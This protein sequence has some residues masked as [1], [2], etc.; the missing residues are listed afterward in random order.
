MI[1]LLIGIVL[2]PIV[3]IVFFR[4]I[5]T[6]RE[7]LAYS[8]NL[9][10]ET[11]TTPP[12]TIIK[13]VFGADAFTEDNTGSWTEQD[14]DGPVEMIFSFQDKNDPAL[15]V[16]EDTPG[17]AEVLVNPVKPGYSGKMSNLYYGQ[18]LAHH[19]FIVMSDSDT[20]ADTNTLARMVALHEQGA[21][22]ITNLTRY[23][24]AD[25]LWG[26]IYAAFWNFE[27]IG[28][29]APSIRKHG[30]GAIGNTI[31]MTQ[32]TLQKLGGLKVFRDYVAED[33]AMG[34]KAEELGIRVDL[35]PIIDSPVG[36]M[37]LRS[38]LNK[39]S[40]AALFGITMKAGNESL[41][42]AVLYSY[43]IVL[44]LAAILGDG[45]FLALGLLL[46]VFRLALASYVWW[47]TNSQKRLF[48]E[49][50]LMDVLFLHV[51]IRSF[52]SRTVTWAGIRYKVNPG[53]RMVRLTDGADNR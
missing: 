14:Y 36:E 42:Y 51:F 30:R 32:G 43:L 50:F 48:F 17:Q 5:R 35:G 10:T 25:N 49:A 31:A 23:R 39:F 3:L 52:F 12:V 53:G 1:G 16:V 41:R 4:V 11:S 34:K 46:A 47:L 40:R 24:Y 21:E 2:V 29:L 8:A 7:M 38:L 44:L 20:R 28:F 26:R 33:V 9:S 15:P 37:S 45:S 19:D 22:I 27:Q 6:I 13:P 18:Q